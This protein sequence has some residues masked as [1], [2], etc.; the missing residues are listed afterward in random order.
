M[1]TDWDPHLEGNAHLTRLF[2]SLKS[3]RPIAK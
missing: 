1:H 2:N 3:Y